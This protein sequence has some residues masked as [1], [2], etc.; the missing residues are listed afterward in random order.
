MACCNPCN[1]V[2]ETNTAACE[3]LPS[4]I[5]N[6]TTQFFGAVVKTEVDGVVTWSLPCNLDEGLP[7]NP[8]AEGEGLACYFIRLFEDGIIGLTG[9]QGATGAD[10][11]NGRNAYTVTLASFVQ[12][13]LESPNVQVVT[14]ANPA[15]LDEL[16][17]FIATSGWYLV[18]EADSSGVL[19]LTLVKAVSGAPVTITAGKLVVPSGFPGASITGPQGVQGTKGDQGDPATN[20]STTNGLF[21]TDTGT[22]Y[23]AQIAYTG[24]DFVSSTPSVVLPAAGRYLV[25][26]V[27]GVIGLA[28]VATSDVVT[29]KLRDMSIVGEIAGSEKPISNLVQDEQKQVI[30]NTIVQT[31]GANHSIELFVKATTA[32]KIAVVPEATTIT[33]VRLS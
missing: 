25:T 32:D 24:V 13:S 19:F 12:P 18:N 20:F 11:A 14:S 22:D 9:P 29:F 23:N 5:E 1:S 27:A 33:Y 31:D 21:W 30:L 10:G 6:F 17:V 3:S 7:N 4:Q 28:T 15:I 8:R 2:S 26:V 16:Y